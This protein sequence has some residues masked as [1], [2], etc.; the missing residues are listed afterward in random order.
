M[1]ETY[2]QR[3]EYYRPPCVVCPCTAG[4]TCYIGFLPGDKT[5]LKYPFNDGNRSLVE[6]EAQI[7]ETLGSH[8]H[9]LK[10]HGKHEHGLVLDYA[11]NGSVKGYLQKNPSTPTKQRITWCWEL[12]EAMVHAHSKCVLH[13][14]ISASNL[15]LD[16]SLSSKLADFQG[17][18]KDPVPGDTVVTG[19]IMEA[20][21]WFLAREAGAESVKFVVPFNYQ[22]IFRR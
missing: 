21:K 10:Y 14:N 4:S 1:T 7:F 22:S 17:T 2:V 18:L 5:V 8:L 11:A 9:I 16:E 13:C 6:V 12:A 3:V 15:L 19:G 20:S